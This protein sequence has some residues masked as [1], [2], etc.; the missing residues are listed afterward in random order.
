MIDWSAL[1]FPKD[2][3]R[4]VRKLTQDRAQ[5]AAERKVRAEVLA[6]DHRRCVVPGC[7]KSSSDLHHIKPRSLGGLFVSKNLASCCR[8]HHRWITAGL[9]RV[10]GNPNSQRGCTVQVTALGREARVRIGKV[11]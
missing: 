6:R 7:R 11:A 4:V 8:D 10:T 5:A 9:L 3:P 1:A 2:P